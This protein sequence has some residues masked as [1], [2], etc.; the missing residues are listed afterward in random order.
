MPCNYFEKIESTNDEA[1][2]RLC[3]EDSDFFIYV[4]KEQTHGRGRGKNHW[5][6]PGVETSILSSWVTQLPSAVQFTAS[7]IVGLCLYI[8]SKKAWPN[9][10]FKIKPPNDLYIGH[11]KTAGLLIEAI[12]QGHRN[13][14]IIGLGLNLLSHPAE[15]DS[16][17]S[18]YEQSHTQ[19]HNL[20]RDLIIFLDHFYYELKKYKQDMTQPL[21]RVSICEVLSLAIGAVEVTPNCDIITAE[22]CISWRDL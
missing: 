11:K 8:A 7:P 2:K 20:E 19:P 12:Q 17:T 1:K 21:L 10:E 15:I 22:K 18:V 13:Y 5:Q 6:Q 16:A 3:T 14:L 4:A 9:L